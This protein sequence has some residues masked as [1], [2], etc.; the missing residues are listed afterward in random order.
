M[1]KRSK[2]RPRGVIL[3]TM[4]WLKSGMMKFTDVRSEAVILRTKN[5]LALELLRKGEGSRTEIGD[6]MGAMNIAEALSDLGFGPEFKQ[7]FIDAQQALKT[8]VIRS[9]E[10]KRFVL[11]AREL[12]ALNLG[13]EIHDAQ[14]DVATV[15][16]IE[17]ALDIERKNIRNHKVDVV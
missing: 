12:T 5:H 17:T 11:T 13:M 8:L 6:L 7:Q 15:K 9:K 10:T 2:Y 4:N 14:L 16:D 3:D 1:K